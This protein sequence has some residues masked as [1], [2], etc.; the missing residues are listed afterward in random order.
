MSDDQEFIRSGAIFAIGEALRENDMRL[1]A[2]LLQEWFTPEQVK[3]LAAA[4]APRPRR[5]R[6]NKTLYD[7]PL[8]TS[9]ERSKILGRGRT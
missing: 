7:F 3:T 5:A 1:A 6:K 4:L 9:R 8:P 2:K